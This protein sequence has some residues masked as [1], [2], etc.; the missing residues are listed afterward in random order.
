M[1]EAGAAFLLG[2]AIERIQ[3]GKEGGAAFLVQLGKKVIVEGAL[4]V[5]LR[6]AQSLGQRRREQKLTAAVLGIGLAPKVALAL[7][8]GLAV[9]SAAASSVWVMPG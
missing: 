5:R 9:F 3:R 6:V 7:K 2:S 8:A 1:R 4:R